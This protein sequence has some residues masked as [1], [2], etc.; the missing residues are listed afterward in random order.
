MMAHN[1]EVAGLVALDL[2]MTKKKNQ[3]HLIHFHPLISFL[4]A[5]RLIPIL[6][7]L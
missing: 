5:M 3:S 6:K 1:K 2:K 7:K 4:Y